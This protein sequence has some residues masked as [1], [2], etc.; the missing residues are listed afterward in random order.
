MPLGCGRGYSEAEWAQGQCRG[1]ELAAD[2]NFDTNGDGEITEADDPIAW[3]GGAG[4]EP[5]ARINPVNNRT[6]GYTGH[7]RG[8]GYK[9]S[10]MMINSTDLRYVRL[11]GQLGGGASVVDGVQLVGVDIRSSYPHSG[12]VQEA[13]VGGLAGSITGGTLVRH[14]SVTGKIDAQF[15]G[16]ANPPG[17]RHGGCYQNGQHLDYHCRQLDGG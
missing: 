3:N 11:F 7:F 10:N 5:I 17:R 16:S 6:E 13:A 12:A 14:S 15:Q 2:I 4:W 9:I 1:Y 8:N